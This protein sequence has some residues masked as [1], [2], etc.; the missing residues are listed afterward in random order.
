MRRLLLFP[1]SPYVFFCVNHANESP[2]YGNALLSPEVMVSRSTVLLWNGFVTVA[3]EVCYNANSPIYAALFLNNCCSCFKEGRQEE[4]RQNKAR[5]CAARESIDI[6]RSTGIQHERLSLK[7]DTH[8]LFQTLTHR[9][10]S[11]ASI[12]PSKL[13]R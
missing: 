1:F 5:E 6:K 12:P 11:V 10:K 8:K 13:R 4:L 2:V 3:I 9:H 7:G